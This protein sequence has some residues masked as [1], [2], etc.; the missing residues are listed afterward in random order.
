MT[1]IVGCTA[2]LYGKT[3]LEAAIRSVIDSVEEHHVL[4]CP[5]PSHGYN[6]GIL[7]PDTEDELHDIAWKAAGKKLRWNKGDWQRENEQRSSILYY[8]PNA[9][10]IVI[11]DS[12]EIYADHLAHDAIEWGLASGCG[13]LRLPFIH[14]W[15]TFKRGFTHDPA[16]PTRIVFP[17]QS[18][19]TETMPTNRSIW[20]YGYA[21]PSEIVKYKVQN[22]GHL[23]EFRRDVNWFDDVF[24]ANRQFD[25]HP[26]GSE[27]WDCGDIDLTKLPSVL[28]NHP[29]K[30]LDLIP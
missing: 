17:K 20:H 27:H 7:P 9:D 15:R 24:M 11:V 2:L 10:A 3:Y 22:H 18:G 26:I 1:K 28:Q 12:D 21:Q 23:S 14:M 30:D 16:Y 6:N 4:Y 19:A 8:A 13:Q 5:H 29:Y 25:C